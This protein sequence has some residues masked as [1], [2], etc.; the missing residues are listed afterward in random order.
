MQIHISWPAG[1]TTATIEE[2]PTSKALAGVL[3]II[4]TARTWGEEVY[5]DTPV[6]VPTEADARQVVEPGT[7]AFWTE[8]DA[9]ALPYGPTPISRGDECRLA[10]PC[11]ILG[12]LD[13]DPR[14]LSTVR[15]G[16]PIRVELITGV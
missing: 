3:P 10:S 7:V 16:D 15:D 4:S 11:N 9:L 8:G 12:T 1:H 2:T 14:V 5:F 6:S 13:D